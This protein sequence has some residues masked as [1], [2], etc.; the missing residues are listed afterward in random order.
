M[1]RGAI[2]DIVRK[3]DLI[4]MLG[5]FLLEKEGERDRQL[6]SQ[7]MRELGRLLQQLMVVEN[8]EAVQLSGFIKLEKFDII[9]KAVRET[10]GFMLPIRG[11]QEVNIPSLVL[12]LGHSL[13]KCA[14]LLHN[15]AI[16][17]RN[18]LMAKEIKYFQKLMRSEWE[19]KISHHS[20]STLK[21]RKMNAVQVLPLAEDM[22]KLRKFGEEGITEHSRQLKLSPTSKNW[23]ALVRL[24]LAGVVML[25]KQRSGE[26]AKLL[27]N[28]YQG[29]PAWRKST[30][31]EILSSLSPLEQRLSQR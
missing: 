31:S 30:T 11:Q 22:K 3:E 23:T 26:A 19:Y 10:T 21:E 6:V 29:I 1:N 18:D 2:A 13:S 16:L 15:Q 24:L 7:K 28:S 27:L 14:T 25:N 20:L 4:K 9:I 8:N 5:A 12:K 17:A